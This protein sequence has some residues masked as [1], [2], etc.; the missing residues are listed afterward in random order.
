LFYFNKA[1][2]SWHKS[3]PHYVVVSFLMNLQILLTTANP[4]KGDYVGHCPFCE[5]SGAA[6][7]PVFTFLSVIVLTD[8]FSIIVTAV[9]DETRTLSILILYW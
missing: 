3:E 8:L 4:I 7:T 2:S 5:V 9:W 6:S 1:L